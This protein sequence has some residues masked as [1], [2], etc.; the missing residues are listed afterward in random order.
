MGAGR[1]GRGRGGA[2]GGVRG[3]AGAEEAERA[4]GGDHRGVGWRAAGPGG[5]A[6]ADQDPRRGAVRAADVGLPERARTCPTTTPRRCGPGSASTTRSRADLAI[7]GGELPN[8]RLQ[9]ALEGLGRG[10]PL[11]RTLSWVHW[12]WFFEPHGSLVWIL[13]KHPERFPRAARQ[14]AGVF[15]LGCV[16]YAAVPT[17]PPW[18]AAENGHADP[19]VQ[20]DHGRG[21]RG[22]VGPLLGSPLRLPR[23]QP[24]GG[25][26][27]APLRRLAD[28]GDPAERG[29]ARSRG[30]WGGP[31][32]ARSGSRSSIWG[33]TT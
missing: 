18:W 33:S 4:S 8:V 12:L 31:T 14:M 22:A 24:V 6:A 19:R 15:D 32:P 1:P 2:R 28:G 9:R 23:G 16:V 26:A 21:R 20:A 3:A 27:L 30:R 7:G 17:A 25:D 5:A 13:A 10:N 29:R 11:D